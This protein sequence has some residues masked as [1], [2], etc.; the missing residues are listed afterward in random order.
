MSTLV[1]PKSPPGGVRAWGRFPPLDR[2]DG[3]PRSDELRYVS[4]VFEPEALLDQ[5]H[6]MARQILQGSP[7]SHT[8]IKALVYEG[9]GIDVGEHVKNHTR[10][11]AE[12]FK[13]EDHKEGVASFLERRP[14]KFTGR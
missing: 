8:R 2:L 7:F 1:V 5:P 13:S 9:L 4:G 6:T 3:A 11:L 12:C 14:A 10:A